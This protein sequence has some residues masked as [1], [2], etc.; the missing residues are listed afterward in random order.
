MTNFIKNNSL[1]DKFGRKIDYIRLSVTD[2]CDLRCNYCLPK[3][4]KD[5]AEPEHWLSFDELEYLVKAWVNL[6]VRRVRLTGGEPLL[7]RNLPEL[8]AKLSAIPHLE[9]LSLSTNGTQLER[10]SDDLFKAGLNRLNI[11]LDSLNSHCTH[12]ITGRDILPTVLAGIDSA[13]KSG[14]KRI[15]INMVVQPNIN[16][17]EIETM[18]Q[19]CTDRSL[20]LRLIETM[21]VGHSKIHQNFS[22]LNLIRN[23]LIKN[24]NLIP[25]AI[26]LGGGPARY[27]SSK[28]GKTQIGFITPLSQHFCQ[29]CNRVRIGVDGMLYLCLGQNDAVPLRP[30]LNQPSD[31][32]ENILRNAINL[33]PERHEFVENP[34]KIIR[35]MSQTGG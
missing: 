10:L 23:N 4:F 9:D 32:L 24:F 1:I 15:K 31:I 33:K 5:F 19:F 8:I 29:T 34:D 26:E 18:V 3:G 7:R 35:F 13:Q 21:P 25:S 30:L 2:R 11:S 17:H 22:N 12:K 16:E 14:F 27:W 6:G 20:I 28:N